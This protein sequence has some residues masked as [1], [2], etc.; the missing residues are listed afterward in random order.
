MLRLY[1]TCFG[2]FRPASFLHD[3]QSSG[4][5]V[6]ARARC[7]STSAL[8]NR[9]VCSATIT[10][11][12]HTYGRQSV[13]A[14]IDALCIHAVRSFDLS[15]RDDGNS[16]GEEMYVMVLSGVRRHLELDKMS[17]G[18]RG[19]SEKSTSFRAL[20]WALELSEKIFSPHRQALNSRIRWPARPTSNQSLALLIVFSVRKLYGKSLR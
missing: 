2:R 18:I 3:R 15:R 13:L 9:G 4:R 12:H 20:F 10:R 8:T 7:C 16:S 5:E 6:L 17:A 14:I 11:I 19:C 1:L